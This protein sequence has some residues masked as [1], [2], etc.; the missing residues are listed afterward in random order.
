[1]IQPE[2]RE[3]VTALLQQMKGGIGTDND[4]VL[5]QLV[6][7]CSALC[8]SVAQLSDAVAK[9]A[10]GL[11]D[12]YAMIDEQVFD[13]MEKA[14]HS[15]HVQILKGKLN[16]EGRDFGEYSEAYRR[17]FDK[18]L[19][20][21][22]AEDLLHAKS[23]VEEGQEFDEESWL[24]G[25]YASLRE[26]MGGISEAL[27]G[28]PTV[29]AAVVEESHDIDDDDDEDKGVDDEAL[30]RQAKERLSQMS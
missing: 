26:R 24:K 10:D 28:K 9:V 30:I 6:E 8:V 7:I 3:D 20:E 1:M 21:E 17:I 23:A 22:I 5:A 18:D 29:T 15:K 27:G 16:G 12:A 2:N 25:R 14:V 11:D 13:P 4:S 19:L